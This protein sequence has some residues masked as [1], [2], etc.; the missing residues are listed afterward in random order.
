MYMYKTWCIV[1][2][3]KGDKYS[4]CCLEYSMYIYIYL[5]IPRDISIVYFL[6]SFFSF[7]QRMSLFCQVRLD[8]LSTDGVLSLSYRVIHV[9]V[10]NPDHIFVGYVTF[11]NMSICNIEGYILYEHMINSRLRRYDKVRS[12]LYYDDKNQ[13]WCKKRGHCQVMGFWPNGPIVNAK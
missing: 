7:F 2:I 8:P 13:E 5:I 1:L 11:A 4:W 12:N 9:I 6:F 10:D 3:S